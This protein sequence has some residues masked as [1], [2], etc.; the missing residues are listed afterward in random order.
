[1]VCRHYLHGKPFG[2]CVEIRD[3]HGITHYAPRV[4][5]AA[6]KTFYSSGVDDSPYTSVI[7]IIVDWH[8]G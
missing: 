1:M 7:V 8:P 5:R 2:I 3:L 6:E 4:E